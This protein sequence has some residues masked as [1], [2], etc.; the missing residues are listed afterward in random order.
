MIDGTDEILKHWQHG[1]NAL[2]IDRKDI[3]SKL[4]ESPWPNDIPVT[5]RSMTK[6]KEIWKCWETGRDFYYVD[7]GYMGNLMKKKI[8]YRV[9]KNNIQHTSHHGKNKN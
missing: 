3:S 2:I 4:Q 6:R 7:N 5:F 1:T 8:W 9:V